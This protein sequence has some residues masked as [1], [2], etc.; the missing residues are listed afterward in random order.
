MLTQ[1]EWN[2]RGMLQKIL[3]HSIRK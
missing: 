3:E 1:K 2:K